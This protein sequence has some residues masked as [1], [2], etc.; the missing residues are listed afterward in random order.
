MDQQ[1][2]RVY[3]YRQ[4]ILDGVGCRH[5]ILEQIEQQIEK[6]VGACIRIRMFGAES[7]SAKWAS[8]KLWRANLEARDFRNLDP[9]CRVSLRQLMLRSGLP[10]RKFW[11][12]DRRE[13]ASSKNDGRRL[14]LGCACQNGLTRATAPIISVNDLKK[15][16]RENRLMR[17]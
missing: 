8:K 10:R 6:Y 11:I 14:E 12:R 3:S 4:E 16:P 17:N 9:G 7:Y 15:M 2:K 5:M 13:L 1:R